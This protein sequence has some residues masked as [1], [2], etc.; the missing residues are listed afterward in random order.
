M[1]SEEDGYGE[2]KWGKLLAVYAEIEDAKLWPH[3][4]SPG[5][6]LVPGDG[7][8]TAETARVMVVGEAP[9]AVE[10]GSG[11]PF[12]GPSGR[13]LDELLAVAGLERNQCFITNVVKYHP[14]GNRTPGLGEAIV[15]RAPLRAEF[16][17]ITPILVVC[18][19]AV[20][21]KIVHPHGVDG[22]EALSKMQQGALTIMRN[23]AYAT[24]IYHPAF[25]IRYPKARERIEEAWHKLGEE[26][27]EIPSLATELI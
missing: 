15:G 1:E 14:L 9:G 12:S 25:G 19:G 23:G 11:R 4:R 22:S 20:A 7:P 2:T 10:N 5:I 18:V 16:R 24:S 26:I 13:L 3:L 8:E 21:H 6:R 27:A 17:I